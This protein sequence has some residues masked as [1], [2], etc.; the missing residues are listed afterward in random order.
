MTFGNFEQNMLDFKIR[1]LAFW[2]NSHNKKTLVIA[3]HGFIK[4]I[5]K[6]PANQIYRAEKLREQ[7]F[8]NKTQN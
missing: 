6:V 2:D 8:K 7:Y 1:L 3:S 5:D 4:K